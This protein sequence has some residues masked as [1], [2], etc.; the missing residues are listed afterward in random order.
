MKRAMEMSRKVLGQEHQQTLTSMANLATILKSLGRDS[1]AITLLNECFQLQKQVLGEDHV[2][3]VETLDVLN[4][5]EN[6]KFG[7][8]LSD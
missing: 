3:T 6:E 4:E 5:W 2:D 8:G 7:A 1:E